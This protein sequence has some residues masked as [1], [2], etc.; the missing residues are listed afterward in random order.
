MRHSPPKVTISRVYS[1]MR[2]RYSRNGLHMSLCIAHVLSLLKGATGA[3]AMIP[4][5]EFVSAGA[6]DH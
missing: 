4:W 3:C 5:A 1:R 6:A 2:L